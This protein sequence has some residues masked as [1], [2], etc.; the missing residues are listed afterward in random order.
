MLFSVFF[1]V[2]TAC[3]CSKCICHIDI[4]YN[5]VYAVKKCCHSVKSK[6]AK[7]HIFVILSEQ[8][9]AED[10]VWRGTHA[11]LDEY[12]ASANVAALM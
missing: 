7:R 3:M 9:R 11:T 12:V 2:L 4:I 8:K 1:L 5:I 10:W 6:H